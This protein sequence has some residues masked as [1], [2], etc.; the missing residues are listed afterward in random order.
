M[1][2]IPALSSEE[3]IDRIAQQLGLIPEG[4][5]MA[6][7]SENNFN[8]VKYLP[9]GRV[10]MAAVPEDKV[11]WYNGEINK[12]LQDSDHCISAPFP[13]KLVDPAEAPAAGPL[14]P[15][16]SSRLTES[17]IY[18]E[19][20]VTLRRES[21]G[22]MVEEFAVMQPAGDPSID[23][24]ALFGRYVRAIRYTNPKGGE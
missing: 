17:E 10:L 4:L 19:A 9:N 6:G 2:G 14:S 11:E 23:S 13:V 1:D 16:E 12:A 7:D 20:R 22:Q 8:V 24:R 21:D 18:V 5:A 3:T 15:A